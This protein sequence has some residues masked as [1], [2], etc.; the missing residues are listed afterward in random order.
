M[1][2]VQGR[3]EIRIFTRP[4]NESMFGCLL[5]SAAETGISIKEYSR[6]P[7]TV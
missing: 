2:F 1:F 7:E 3:R 4:D 6:S 5:Y